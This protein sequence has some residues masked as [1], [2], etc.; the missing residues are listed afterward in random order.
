MQPGM[1]ALLGSISPAEID[2]APLG[3]AI[4]LPKFY[5]RNSLPPFSRA[6]V[7]GATI[8]GAIC[9]SPSAGRSIPPITEVRTEMVLAGRTMPEIIER[10]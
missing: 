3:L 9:V 6:S 10:S 5:G 8:R 2:S 4:P 1:S 7:R